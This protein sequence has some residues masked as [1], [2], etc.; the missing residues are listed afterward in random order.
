MSIV[1]TYFQK[2]IEDAAEA[3]SCYGLN[4]LESVV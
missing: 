4:Y 3:E 2:S 1:N